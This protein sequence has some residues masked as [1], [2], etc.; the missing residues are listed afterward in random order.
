[1]AH[2]HLQ[3]GSFTLFWVLVWWA[4]ALVV[5]GAALAFLR[6]RKPDPRRITIAAFLT[7]AAFALSQVEIPV[8]G[9]VH[10]SLTPLIG[11]LTGP[12]IGSLIVQVT[13]ILSAGVGHGGW[14]M[15]GANTLVNLSEVV[16]AYG[17]FRVLRNML[18]D[19]AVR[20]GIATFAGLLCGNLVMI[21]I[22]LVSG[23]QGVNQ[24]P[25]QIL[26]GLTLIAAVNMGVAVVEAL[27]TGLVV[28]SVGKMRPDLLD[29]GRGNPPGPDRRE[30]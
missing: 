10:I 14:G 22:V 15:I 19:L 29:G 21:A 7:A 16:V 25:E 11:I 6:I 12:V 4:V 2:I 18:P 3:D 9:G 27:M 23:I 30:P 26:A 13:N 17:I 24:G 1:M 5:I 20:A 8:A 28:S